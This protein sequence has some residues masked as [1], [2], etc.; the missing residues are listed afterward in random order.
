[1]PALCAHPAAAAP[2]RRYGLSLSALIIGSITPDF[3]YFFRVSTNAQFGHSFA[4]V[5]IFCLPAGLLALGLFH[6]V[7][8]KPL[9]SLLPE[10]HQEC[11]SP[12]TRSVKFFS[13]A[14]ELLVVM[15]AVLL[16]AWTH[17]LWDSCTHSYG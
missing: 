7:L 4:G 14:R 13:S 17:I 16:G 2:L 5:F 12:F 6:L 9:F 11:L 15:L 8:K 1:M 10:S 3:L